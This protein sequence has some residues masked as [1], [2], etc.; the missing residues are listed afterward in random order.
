MSNHTA[1]VVDKYAA[2]DLAVYSSR[3]SYYYSSLYYY[4]SIV[5]VVSYA[6]AFDCR[7]VRSFVEFVVALEYY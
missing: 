7:A 5:E 1:A 6:V 2:V 4:S 3:Y